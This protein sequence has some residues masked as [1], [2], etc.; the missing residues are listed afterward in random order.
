MVRRYYVILLEAGP[1]PCSRILFLARA[2]SPEEEGNLVVRLGGD[3]FVLLLVRIGRPE[4]ASLVA[5][6]VLS[7]LDLSSTMLGYCGRVLGG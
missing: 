2:E 6:R 3:E 7:L 1:W 4:D 5:K